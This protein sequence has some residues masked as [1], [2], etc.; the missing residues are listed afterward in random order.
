[1]SIRLLL[2]ASIVVFGGAYLLLRDTFD[3]MEIAPTDS[4]SI[5]EDSA[6]LKPP[7]IVAAETGDESHAEFARQLGDYILGEASSEEGGMHWTQ[8]EHRTRPE[9]VQAQTGWM[10]GAAGVGAFFLHLDAYAKGQAPRIR[11]PDSPWSA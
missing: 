11:F 4:L 2:I 6:I 5:G 10:Q 3:P 1:M 7:V 8:A 9:F